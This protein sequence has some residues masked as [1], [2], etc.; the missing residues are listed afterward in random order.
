MSSG[1]IASDQ[2]SCGSTVVRQRLARLVTNLTVIV[3]DHAFRGRCFL[4]LVGVVVILLLSVILDSLR[5]VILR[6]FLLRSHLAI[7][8]QSVLLNYYFT[9]STI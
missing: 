1:L 5:L 6:G 8:A 2:R 9:K 7:G 4:T 3:S